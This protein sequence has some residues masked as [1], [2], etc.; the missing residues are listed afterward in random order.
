MFIN[1]GRLPNK[2]QIL[3]I[4]CHIPGAAFKNFDNSIELIW[5]T[6]QLQPN[7]EK[8]EVFYSAINLR[9]PYFPLT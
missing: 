3:L 5:V 8:K 6:H 2:M 4:S 1:F 9:Q 7:N